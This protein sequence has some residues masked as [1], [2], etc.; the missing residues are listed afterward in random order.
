MGEEVKKASKIKS[1]PREEFMALM[2]NDKEEIFP[3]SGANDWI[4][5]PTRFKLREAKYFLKQ[6]HATYDD[7]LK[8]TTGE[9]RD[10]FLFSLGAFF[11]RDT[12]Y[13][14]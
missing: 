10:I 14:W 3:A 2:T 5:N 1:Y 7:Y 8:N 12:K 11:F 9:N 6:V 4:E 13:Y